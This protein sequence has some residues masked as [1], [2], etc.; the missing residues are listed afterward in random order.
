[1]GAAS[2]GDKWQQLGMGSMDKQS[3]FK[4]LDAYYDAGGN[5][6]DTANDCEPSFSFFPNTACPHPLSLL[7]DQDESSEEFIGEWAE[8]RGIRD[9]LVI[10]TK[11]GI[12]LSLDVRASLILDTSSSQLIINVE[13]TASLSR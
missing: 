13:T 7:S 3:S 9:Q 6:I 2:I 5:F 8:K 4:L 10:A 12:L 1:L 11:A